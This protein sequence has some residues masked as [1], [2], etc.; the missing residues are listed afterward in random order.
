MKT[1]QI[2]VLTSCNAPEEILRATLRDLTNGI[3]PY[4]VL[5]ELNGYIENPS[6][7]ISDETIAFVRKNSQWI[8]KRAA[9]VEAMLPK[10]ERTAF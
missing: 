5:M 6:Q 1:I 9:E 3:I 8:N 10:P 2:N 4:G 7:P